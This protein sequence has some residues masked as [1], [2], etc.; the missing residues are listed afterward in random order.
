MI[1]INEI[2]HDLFDRT[3]KIQNQINDVNLNSI[4]KKNELFARIITDS[5]LSEVTF[6]LYNNGH[7]SQA[8]EEAYKLLNNTVKEECQSDLDGSKLMQ[9]AFS[10][11]NPLLKFNDLKTQ[12]EKDEQLGFM[13]ILS[14]CM[15]G[16]RNPRAHQHRHYDEQNECLELLCFANYLLRK[17]RKSIKA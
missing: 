16:I 9:N 14:G 15:L 5:D 11:N 13:E 12:S 1:G 8:I 7:Y 2:I 6:K 17:I 3:K 4:T 10:L